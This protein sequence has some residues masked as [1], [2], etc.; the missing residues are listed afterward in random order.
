MIWKINLTTSADKEFSKLPKDSQLFIRSY[1]KDKVMKSPRE[2]G[3]SL[4]SSSKIK[5]WRYRVKNYRMICQIQDQDITV[6]VVRIAK[7]DSVYKNL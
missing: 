2:Y 3:K 7:R 1:L 4:V 5:L 6:L